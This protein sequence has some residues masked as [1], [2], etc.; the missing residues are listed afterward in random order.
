MLNLIHKYSYYLQ[1][2]PLMTKMI[3]GGVLAT[4][5]DLMCQHFEKSK[6]SPTNCVGFEVATPH[7]GS[8][9]KAAWNWTR[10]RNFAIMGTF[11]SAPLLHLHFSKF[12]PWV[13]PK[14]TA[15]GCAKKLF[16]D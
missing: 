5:G 3:T 14:A 9:A 11:F 16:A 13:A 6:H 4:V 7:N 15:A 2:R 10:T 1:H 8:D 12:L